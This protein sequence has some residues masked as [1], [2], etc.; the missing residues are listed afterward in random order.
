MIAIRLLVRASAT[1][2]V[3]A[4]GVFAPAQPGEVR[5]TSLEATVLNS[6]AV[7]EATLTHYTLGENASSIV[8]A[9]FEI[10]QTLKGDAPPTL[11]VTLNRGLRTFEAWQEGKSHM[12]LTRNGASWSVVELSDPKEPLLTAEFKLLRDPEAVSSAA[13]EAL[14][15]HPGVTGIPTV[16]ITVPADV[17]QNFRQ[18]GSGT[19]V[20]VPVDQQLEHRARASYRSARGLNH[21]EIATI[22]GYFKSEENVAILKALLSDASYATYG[23]SDNRIGH[24][25]R[26]YLARRAA[27]TS[28]ATLGVHAAEPVMDEDIFDPEMVTYVYLERDPDV[29]KKVRGLVE[30]PNLTWVDLAQTTANDKDVRRIAELPG[31]DS[32]NLNLTRI[33]DGGLIEVGRMTRLV[34][35]DLVNT[36]ITDSG[37]AHLSGLQ[38][39]QDLELSGTSIDDRGL[40]EVAKLKN[41]RSLWVANTKVTIPGLAMLQGLKNLGEVHLPQTDWEA[42]DQLFADLADAGLMHTYHVFYAAHDT[43]ATRDDDV[44][45]ALFFYE[46]LTD[47]GLP[48]LA[49]LRNLKELTLPKSAISDAGMKTIAGF[50]KLESLGAN[51]TQVGDQGLKT[52][53]GLKLRSL[54]LA[55]TRVTDAGLA[56]LEGMPRL[57]W[58]VLNQTK[59]SDEGLK[60]LTKLREL[61]NL[62]LVDT[63]VGDRGLAYV[64]GLPRLE[65]LSISGTQVTD[66]G[67]VGLAKLKSLKWLYIWRALRITPEGLGKFR[68]LRPDVAIQR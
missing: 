29:S 18:R 23:Y 28:L 42:G 32:L 50:K 10:N 4:L 34:Q 31:V 30:F 46:K 19:F 39:L 26:A 25:H 22:L 44:V 58:L 3:A 49:C 57:Q 68:R 64:S 33:T 51:D 60:C 63:A 67:L 8:D 21:L 65:S 13:K 66:A 2:L 62:Q 40:V 12:L 14:R 9:T 47:A 38:S 6:D 20:E 11:T 37:L 45:R 5:L 56:T 54:G 17:A 43:R 35:L 7:A 24:S 15:S 41:L 59:I 48:A 1:V 61:R 36:G 55:N 16:R 27:F 53:A 52:V